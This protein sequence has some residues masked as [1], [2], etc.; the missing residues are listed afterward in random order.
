MMFKNELKDGWDVLAYWSWGLTL[1]GGP[2]ASY[3]VRVR[4]EDDQWMF[5]ANAHGDP[6]TLSTVHPANWQKSQAPS[7]RPGYSR[8][9]SEARK[10]LREARARV[11]KVST[12][13]RIREHREVLIRDIHDHLAE[14]S[15]LVMYLA[16]GK[17]SWKVADVE[18]LDAML[19]V[20][21]W[22]TPA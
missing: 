18:R 17:L 2:R 21:Q 5:S 11:A 4:S 6:P 22:E 15:R 8:A 1:G 20:L 3:T 14:D 10:A 9:R 16:V 13:D 19:A 7:K 12:L